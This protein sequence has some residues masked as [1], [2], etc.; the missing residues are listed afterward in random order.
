MSEHVKRSQ[1]LRNIAEPHHNCA[2]STLMPFAAE[3]GLAEEQAFAL[4]ACFGKGMRMGSVC[5]AVTGGL[6]ALGL[7]GADAAVQAEFIR[8][9]REMHGG[10]LLCDDLLAAADEAQVPH[11]VNCDGC[12]ADAVA[13]I[14][15]LGV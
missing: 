4:A 1:E 8:R 13:I 14:D 5:G 6:M 15:D 12:V 9:F 11:K 3:N 7:K 10:R 2:Q